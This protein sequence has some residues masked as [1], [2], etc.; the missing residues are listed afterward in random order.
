ML[1][2]YTLSW[3]HAHRNFP[4]QREADH[5][6]PSR[7]H[8]ILRNFVEYQH[9]AT[10]A[11]GVY[12]RTMDALP[13]ATPYSDADPRTVERAGAALGQHTVQIL[14]VEALSLRANRKYSSSTVYFPATVPP[15]QLLASIVIVPG[16]A[17]SE[18]TI[19]AWGSFF[20][21]Q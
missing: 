5:P 14:A 10:S 17:C 20:A 7:T 18:N 1:P 9:G 3:C 21:S 2:S 16:W 12:A 13:D 4:R 15:Q 19:A 11:V 8:R 6:A